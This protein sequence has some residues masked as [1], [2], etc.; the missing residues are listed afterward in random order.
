MSL[1]VV[2]S[3]ALV[4]SVALNVWLVRHFKVQLKEQAKVLEA[5][6]KAKVVAGVDKAA[7]AVKAEVNKA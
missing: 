7:E 3:V 1:A 5:E 2:L 6:A 4:V